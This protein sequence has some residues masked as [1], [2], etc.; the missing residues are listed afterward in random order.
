MI[1]LILD[2]YVKVTRT[3]ENIQNKINRYKKNVEENIEN[4]K[5]EKE[6]IVKI[7]EFQKTM[8]Q[9]KG[10]KD[11]THRYRL[12]KKKQKELRDI[13]IPG[14]VSLTDSELFIS[15]MR[16]KY[17]KFSKNKMMI[18]DDDEH[19]CFE[20]DTKQSLQNSKFDVILREVQKN[21]N[22]DDLK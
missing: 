19:D 14:I 16:Q 18:I 4:L 8:S 2:E 17:E 13:L 7:K 3:I 6:Q 1:D 15:N 11:I 21:L 12:L 5:N 20:L 10:D 9:I 22:H